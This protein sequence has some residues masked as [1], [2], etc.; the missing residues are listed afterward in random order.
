MATEWL[1]WQ[2]WLPPGKR[3]LFFLYEFP[4]NGKVPFRMNRSFPSCNLASTLILSD[5]CCGTAS[6]LRTGKVFRFFARPTALFKLQRQQFFPRESFC[7]IN[8]AREPILSLSLSL[9]PT[10]SR[11][12]KKKPV[13]LSYLPPAHLPSVAPEGAGCQE[14]RGVAGRRRIIVFPNTESTFRK[15]ETRTVIA[16]R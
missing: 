6:T 10:P 8:F 1:F 4:E 15:L 16:F 7:I 12:R 13:T 5:L 3:V 2:P 9:S 14:E 11:R